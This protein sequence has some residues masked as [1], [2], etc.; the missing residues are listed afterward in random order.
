MAQNQNH[1]AWI[2]LEMT[3]LSPDTD[4]IIELAIVITDSQLEVVAESPVLAVKLQEM[5][6][7]ADTPRIA[8][9]RAWSLLLLCAGALLLGEK[10]TGTDYTLKQA[11]F[12]AREGEANIG[13]LRQFHDAEIAKLVEGIRAE[14]EHDKKRM[15]SEAEQRADTSTRALETLPPE[16]RPVELHTYL[17]VREDG[18]TLYG[19]ATA[20]GGDEAVIF[21]SNG[22]DSMRY[23]PGSLPV[24]RAY[25]TRP[26]GFF[27]YA[28][29]FKKVTAYPEAGNDQAAF[30]DTA[31]DDTVTA[32]PTDAHAL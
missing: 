25:I 14:A 22:D 32:S 12:E 10:L 27:V 8:R 7:L 11:N 1:L 2:D 5:F 4:R 15:I 26:G 20:G 18:Q 28:Q 3:G 17:A 6:G 23:E 13:R 19:F 16:G 31:G 9:G 29:N 24:P 21:G 30:F